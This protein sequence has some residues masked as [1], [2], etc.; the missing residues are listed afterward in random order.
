[1]LSGRPAIGG[2]KDARRIAPRG[3]GR[4]GR[5]GLAPR[6]LAPAKRPAQ[7]D[8]NPELSQHFAKAGGRFFLFVV[9]AGKI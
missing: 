6:R 8:P 7:N 4:P 1:M 3:A 2:G 5:A 9:I